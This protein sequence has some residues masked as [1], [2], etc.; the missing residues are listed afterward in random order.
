MGG[1]AFGGVA[2]RHDVIR[3][4]TVAAAAALV[5]AGHAGAARFA[6]GVDRSVP[7][8]RVAAQLPGHVS[9]RLAALHTLVVDAPHVRGVRQ[10]TGVRWVE[11]LGSRRRKLAF[12]PTDPLASRQW[13]LQQDHAY[14]A[15]P[16]VPP[17]SQVPTR[18]SM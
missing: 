18:A 6:I 11:W 15:W 13:Y 7:L 14:D 8:Q 5:F 12:T 3:A 9:F 16:D 2:G 4:T 1:R 10:I 17:L